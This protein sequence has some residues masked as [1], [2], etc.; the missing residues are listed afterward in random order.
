MLGNVPA[1][2]NQGAGGEDDDES[3]ECGENEID[4]SGEQREPSVAG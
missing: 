4:E 1:R 3:D 2:L